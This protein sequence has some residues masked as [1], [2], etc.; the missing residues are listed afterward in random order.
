MT[1]SQKIAQAQKS[2][3]ERQA[4][5]EGR[6]SQAQLNAIEDLKAQISKRQAQQQ[7]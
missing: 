4:V 2:K 1:I 7:S 6:V 3:E 5:I